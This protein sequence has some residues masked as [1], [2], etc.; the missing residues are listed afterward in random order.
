[1]EFECENCEKELSSRHGLDQHM[2][3][4]HKVEKKSSSGFKL[5]KKWVYLGVILIAIVGMV[6]LIPNNSNPTGFVVADPSKIPDEP[7]HW[8][9]QLSIEIDGRMQIIPA[10][11]GLGPG[12]HSPIHTHAA[13]GVLHLE[14]NYPNAK[15]IS[16]D[17][18]FDVWNKKFDEN[19]I[20][21]YCTNETH[22]LNMYVNGEENFEYSNYLMQAEDKI[23]IEYSTIDSQ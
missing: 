23:L 7:I 17:F 8:H 5:E 4:K 14:N 10:N 9:P 1:M 12:G 20:F 18:F 3:D 22:E 6:K 15:T 13:D 21:D 11:I 19:C 2:V 16:L